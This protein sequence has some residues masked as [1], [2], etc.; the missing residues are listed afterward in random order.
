MRLNALKS[1]VQQGRLAEQIGAGVPRDAQLG[2][3]NDVA[4]GNLLENPDDLRGVGLGIGNRGPNRGTG[5]ANKTKSIHDNQPDGSAANRWP[6]RRNLRALTTG[7]IGKKPQ[8]RRIDRPSSSRVEQ[9]TSGL[10]WH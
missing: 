5:H 9:D 3:Q 2:K 6:E 1:R 8:D 4:V 10:Q 7:M